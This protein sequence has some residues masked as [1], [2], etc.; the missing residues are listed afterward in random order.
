MRNGVK[1]GLGVL[2]LEGHRKILGIW[3]DNELNG[4]GVK[5]KISGTISVG[6]FEVIFSLLFCAYLQLTSERGTARVRKKNRIEWTCV[7]WKFQR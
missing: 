2:S 3:Q 7:H 6:Q 5:Y 1:E 4:L